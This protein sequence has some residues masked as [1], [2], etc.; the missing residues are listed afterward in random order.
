M[1]AHFIAMGGEH[2]CLPDNCQ[3]YE[4]L[5][6]AIDGLDAI[7]ELETWQRIDLSRLETLRD[8][9]SISVKLNADQGGSYCEIS[10]CN[11][12]SPWEH[13][14]GDSIENWPDYEEQEADNL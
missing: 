1:K 8:T 11:C 13:A 9:D 3:A 6:A 4:T 2:G 14:E 7:Y 10:Q 12:A 5:Q